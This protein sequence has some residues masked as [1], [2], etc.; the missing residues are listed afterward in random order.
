MGWAAK[1][2]PGIVPICFLSLFLMTAAVYAR[3]GT[4]P[5]GHERM[6]ALLKEIADNPP[7]E[8]HVFPQ[9]KLVQLREDLARHMAA[10][11]AAGRDAH[12]MEAARLL[13]E[14]GQSELK[15]GNSEASIE[16]LLRSYDLLEGIREPG[17]DLAPHVQSYRLE[18]RF[19]LGVGHMRLAEDQNC[20]LRN[21]AEAC[22]LPIRGGGLHKRKEGSRSAMRYFQEVL[23]SPVPEVTVAKDPAMA[24]GG[25]VAAASANKAVRYH[26]SARWLMNIAAMTLGEY[27]DKVPAAYRIPPEVFRPEIPGFPRFDNVAPKLGLD[28]F[29][30][31]GGVIVD[32]FD[33]DGHLDIVTSTWDITGQ[34]K[35][36]HNNAD[37]TFTDRTKEANL[38][39]FYGGLNMVQADYDNDGDIDIFILRGGWFYRWGRHPNSLLNNNGDGTFTDVTFEAGL[40]EVHYPT[41]AGSWGDYDNDGDLDLFIANEASRDIKSPTQLFRNN[42]DGTFTDVA[43]QSAAKGHCFGMGTVFGDYDNDRFP[44]IFISGCQPDA[45]LHNNGNA[46]F[47]N[48]AADMGIVSPRPSFPTWFWDFDNDGALDLFISASSGSVGVLA[49]NPQGID[50]AASDPAVRALQ[51]SLAVETMR[52]YRNDGQGGFQD[53]SRQQGLT[54]PAQPM[55]ANFGDLD[56]DGYLDFYLGTGDVYY[57]ELTPNVMFLNRKGKGFTNVTMA[58]GFGHLQK[59]H[60][61]SFADLDNDGDQDVYIQMGGAY[62]GDKFYDALFE[63]PGFGNHWVT[64]E[65]AGRRSNRAA[66]GARLRA[67]ILEDG[68]ERSVYRHVNSGGSFGCN[69]LRQTLGL[70]KAE[71]LLSLEIFWPTT[72]R[73]QSFENVPM[74]KVI[75]IVEDEDHYEPVS[76]ATYK[77]G[78]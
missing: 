70:G 57:T 13:L 25:S 48:V 61:V 46:T 17:P 23:E 30:L 56:N 53:V 47:S 6:L 8:H 51:S 38:T 12:T 32:D 15:L 2:R 52:L 39:G 3:A 29:H 66:I 16:A 68:A 28:T 45:L 50:V 76:L 24:A 49:L 5:S 26:Q 22:I 72:G 21:N 43:P 78:G 41:K 44:D 40:G 58:G 60:G 69:P 35:Y 54:Y 10:P 71:R 20:C 59:G 73:T 14:I 64:V 4:A 75:R 42:G 19:H 31:S 36:F 62:P 33:E 77:L 11:P 1:V 63:N 18:V 37:G 27:P 55:G 9:K 65:L 34:T 74:D 7:Y 67:R